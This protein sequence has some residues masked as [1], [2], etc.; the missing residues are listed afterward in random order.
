MLSHNLKLTTIN[1][2]IHVKC[3]SKKKKKSN[4]L[5]LLNHKNIHEDIIFLLNFEEEYMLLS[6]GERK[7]KE[8]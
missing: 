3:Q 1:S 6:L 4:S 7:T 8:K 2:K 5:S